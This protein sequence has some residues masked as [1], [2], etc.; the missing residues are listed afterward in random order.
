MMSPR[1][2]LTAR[3][4]E[5]FDILLKGATSQQVAEA[6]SISK[7]TVENYRGEIVRK[8]GVRRLIEIANP[9]TER[10]IENGVPKTITLADVLATLEAIQRRLDTI[11]AA[12]RV[13]LPNTTTPEAAPTMPR[14]SDIRAKRR[15]RKAR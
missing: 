8:Y 7:R 3:E 10:V 1:T 12:L 2:P 11:D 4:Q 5:V 9:P 14:L 15:A 6:L 13:L